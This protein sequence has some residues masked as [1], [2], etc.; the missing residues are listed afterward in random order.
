[1][2]SCGNQ[3]W[4]CQ[5]GAAAGTCNCASGD[6]TFSLQDGLAQTIIG[7]QGLVNTNTDVI[8]ISSASIPLTMASSS[9]IT[10]SSTPSQTGANQDEPTTRS[11][12]GYRTSASASAASRTT[13]SS[14][15]SSSLSSQSSLTMTLQPTTIT[16]TPTLGNSTA[17]GSS[18]PTTS[19][20]S[21]H[22]VTDSTAFKAGVA[23]GIIAA[24]V[25]VGFLFF[26][27]LR[28]CRRHPDPPSPASAGQHDPSVAEYTD[29][30]VE[31]REQWPL[32]G[33]SPEAHTN[34]AAHG[35][36]PIIPD[37]DQDRPLQPHLYGPIALD[38]YAVTP[39]DS[40]VRR[41]ASR[42]QH[43]LG[44]ASSLNYRPT[45]R[46]ANRPRGNAYRTMPRA[47][48]ARMPEVPEMTQD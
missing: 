47:S 45:M 46:G 43:G 9:A 18:S 31:Y 27:C 40:D 5:P 21:S 48:Q 34:R 3:N 36:R 2:I 19:A 7:I 38:P 24:V 23:G 32:H 33:G 26:L 39:R 4:C 16:V 11:S 22:G 13:S 15:S 1:M 8:P 20:G 41:E 44:A 29:Q 10:T 12:P 17:S 28:K 14:S 42:L 6:G 30:D 25:V 35:L 37:H